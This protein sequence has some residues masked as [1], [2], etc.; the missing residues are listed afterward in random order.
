VKQLQ[1]R[2]QNRHDFKIIK[3]VLK[4]KRSQGVQYLDVPDNPNEADPK[5]WNRIT[6]KKLI[7]KTILERNI[8][9]FGQ[10]KT[11]PFA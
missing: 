4:G 2:E 6:D 9:H 1:H 5:T 7:E 3:N 10:S 8:A 11:T